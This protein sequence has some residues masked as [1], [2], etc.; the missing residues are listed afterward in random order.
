MY[1]TQCNETLEKKKKCPM[2]LQK[3]DPWPPEYSDGVRSTGEKTEAITFWSDGNV[4]YLIF[5]MIS[6]AYN[7]Y[8]KMHIVH[9]ICILLYVS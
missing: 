8:V 7:G 3:A 4:H 1:G 9:F 2:Y 5:L 6:Q